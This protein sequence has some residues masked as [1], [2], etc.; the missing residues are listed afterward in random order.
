MTRS[1]NAKMQWSRGSNVNDEGTTSGGIS[2]LCFKPSGT[3]IG[4]LGCVVIKVKGV[5]SRGSVFESM[6]TSVAVPLQ[7]LHAL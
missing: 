2:A 4:C 6:E 3:D 5:V 1:L 7:Y